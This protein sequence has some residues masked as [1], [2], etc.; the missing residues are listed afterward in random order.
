MNTKIPG[1]LPIAPQPIYTPS[2]AVKSSEQGVSPR[3][4]P[5]VERLDSYTPE[6]RTLP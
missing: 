2:S 1:S 6:R 3:E 4:A 5:P